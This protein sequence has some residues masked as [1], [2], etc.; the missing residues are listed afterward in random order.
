MEEVAGQ[1]AAAGFGYYGYNVLS[2]GG[3]MSPLATCR[4]SVLSTGNGDEFFLSGCVQNAQSFY[5]ALQELQ[6]TYLG[7]RKELGLDEHSEIWL[8]FFL[9]DITN[10]IPT[11]SACWNVSP[12]AFICPIGQP[13]ARPGFVSL[14]SYHVRS[15]SLRKE[16]RSQGLAFSHGSYT[17][18]LANYIPLKLGNAK[19]QTDEIILRLLANLRHDNARLAQNVMRTWYYIRDVDN[20]YLDMVASRRRHYEMEGLRPDTKFIASTGIEAHASEP[21]ALSW[22]TVLTTLGLQAEQ[23][24]HLKALDKLSPTHIYGVNF[25]RATRVDFG[26]RAHIHVSGTA[27][28]DRDGQVL[29]VADVMKQYD[30]TI[31]NIAALL[32]E[33]GMGLNDMLYGIV[34]L[35]DPAEAERIGK[36]IEQEWK[37]IP[38]IMVKGAVCRPAWLIEVEG[39][40]GVAHDSVKGIA[41]F[42]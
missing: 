37:S 38:I 3:T 34:Y 24:R 41:P 25:E 5:D 16:K 7:L 28:I 35:R 39:L 36:I 9:S 30:R 32:G 21:W 12:E 29:Y 8:R 6:K 10:Q 1:L 19:I 22:M 11:L 27:S 31:E 23:V 20:N 13:P 18:I 2:V 17:S 33:G 26:D 40:A 14:L 15:E 42:L 4:H